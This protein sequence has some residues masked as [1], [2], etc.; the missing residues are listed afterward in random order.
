MGTPSI[1]RS[2]IAPFVFVVWSADAVYAQ[3]LSAYRGFRL[4]M[5]VLE[6]ATRAERP[7]TAAKVVFERPLLIQELEWRPP[8][9]ASATGTLPE[10]DSVAQVLFGFCNG[11]LYG[12][13]VS[14][15]ADRT[16]GLTEQDLVEA[17]STAYG[18]ARMLIARIITSPASQGHN[19][20]EAVTAR[21]EDE[22][23]SID[24]CKMRWLSRPLWRK[25]VPTS[26]RAEDPS[27]DKHG[28]SGR[29][30]QT[31]PAGA[32]GSSGLLRRSAVEPRSPR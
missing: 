31:I 9:V 28:S 16:E 25:S 15:D 7:V 18:P 19:D 14:N 30:G 10:R 29:H 22:R 26:S 5:T 20:T 1:T 21:W 17:L 32:A 2:L 27:Q 13:V 11:E 12:I 4:G 23:S 24:L 3:D 6:V 8:S